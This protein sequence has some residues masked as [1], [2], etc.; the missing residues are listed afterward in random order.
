MS[1]SFQAAAPRAA[2]STYALIERKHACASIGRQGV[3]RSSPRA[4]AGF[5][6]LEFLIAFAIL[7]LFLS[8]FLTGIAVALRGDR[9]AHFITR[10]TM[11]AQT[12]LA[13][14]GAEYSLRPGS[15]G[16]VEPGGYRWRVEIQPYSQ[17]PQTTGPFSA[18][19]LAATVVDPLSNGTRSLTMGTM[20][21][22]PGSGS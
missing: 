7:T 8:A 6:L 11:I 16:G 12:K 2:K 5:A 18:Y 1:V 9:Q 21:L 19:W 3:S 14:A 20:L 15:I 22:V 13:A 17:R 4:D 10:A